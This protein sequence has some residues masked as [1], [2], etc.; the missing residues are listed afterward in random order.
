MI[1]RFKKSFDLR[2]FYNI[3]ASRVA[4]KILNYLDYGERKSSGRLISI[5]CH[6]AQEFI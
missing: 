1:V 3:I 5:A 4:T 6:N 2:F